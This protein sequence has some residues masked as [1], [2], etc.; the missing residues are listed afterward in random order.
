VEYP[1]Y[2]LLALLSKALRRKEVVILAYHSV[3]QGEE[4]HTVHLRDFAQQIEYLRE[5]YAI[6]CLRDIAEYLH[7]K[8]KL[9]E[10]ALALTFDDGF[11]D[12]YSKV[13]PYLKRY[14]LPATVFVA[15]GYVGKQWPFNTHHQKMLTWEEIVKMSEDDI[16]I[17]AHT[18]THLNLEETY[19]E[20]AKEE[21]L[22][23][24]RET[25]KHV[26]KEVKFFCYP[27]GRFSP[28]IVS[29]VKK[30]GFQAACGNIG[31]ICQSTDPFTMSR[32]Q[33]DSSV[34]FPLFVARLTRAVDW[35]EKLKSLVWKAR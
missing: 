33:V 26:K 31:T 34:S 21:I 16:E 8:K 24:K 19:L 14:R 12:F 1:V 27:F 30:V 13:Y 15:T 32:V 2:I 7:K 17:G 4:F 9:P 28:S 22:T 18:V 20:V 11:H 35:F 23:S 5:R 10:K 29:I 3:G 6:I 25:E